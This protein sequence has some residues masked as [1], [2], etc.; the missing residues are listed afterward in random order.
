M[1]RGGRISIER[2]KKTEHIPLKK[3]VFLMVEGE[4]EAVYFNRV[5][6]LTDRYNIRSKVSRDKKCT[7]IIKNCAKQGDILGLEEGDL[8]VAVF[9][10]D[11]VDETL[12]REAVSLAEELDVKI[13]ASNLSFEFW[14]LLHLED[15]PHVYTQDDYEASLSQLLGRKYIKTKGLGDRLDLNSI[16]NAVKRGEKILPDSDPIK[17]KVISNSSMLWE[18]LKSIT[19]TE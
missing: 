17:C 4:S 5:A 2:H 14:L 10:L 15:T 8:K 16:Q 1:T 6:R 19:K 13:M 3:T 9:D 18:I 7:D 11:V 12:L